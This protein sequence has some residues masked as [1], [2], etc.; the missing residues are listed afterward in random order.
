ME[1]LGRKKPYR[2]RSLTSSRDRT[3]KKG[4]KSPRKNRGRNYSTAVRTQPTTG[5]INFDED[6]Q[7]IFIPA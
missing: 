3:G 5:R 1:G 4:R 6:R 2:E 7:K